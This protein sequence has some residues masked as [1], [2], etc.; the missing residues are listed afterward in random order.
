MWSGLRGSNSL[1]S[2]WQGDALPDELN[3]HLSFRVQLI[4]SHYRRKVKRKFGYFFF[5]CVCHINNQHAQ[6]ILCNKT[7]A[8][9]K[10]QRLLYPCHKTIAVFKYREGVPHS[11]G[12]SAK[13]GTIFV[14]TG[15]WKI[16]SCVN[17][18]SRIQVQ[19]RLLKRLL[20]RLFRLIVRRLH[21]VVQQMPLVQIQPALR[22]LQMLA[23]HRMRTE[24]SGSE[25]ALPLQSMSKVQLSPEHTHRTDI[26]LFND[27][28]FHLQ[29]SVF[30]P[31]FGSV[32]FSERRIYILS[33]S[34]IP[35][36]KNYS[37]ISSALFPKY[38]AYN[39]VSERGRF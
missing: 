8:T 1:P 28:S 18:I 31:S 17:T 32:S 12:K 36:K 5:L 14:N 29:T 23:W 37:A 34:Q 6:N 15:Q 9:V 22:P 25:S 33:S 16:S 4:L 30:D 20:Q 21:T 7:E 24:R 35:D 19:T 38:L 27:E 3:P 26:P 2:P 13:S 10:P 11:R 39:G